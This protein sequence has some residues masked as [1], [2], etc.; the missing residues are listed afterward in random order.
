M[1]EISL[2]VFDGGGGFV[3]RESFVG[4]SS[5]SFDEKKED[6]DHD[7]DVAD[8]RSDGGDEGSDDLLQSQISPEEI[9]AMRRLSLKST[10][11]ATAQGTDSLAAAAHGRDD[12]DTGEHKS[13]SAA[14]GKLA[15]ALD[16][17]MVSKEDE[18]SEADEGEITSPAAAS[19][20]KTSG[21]GNE[22]TRSGGGEG[23]GGGGGGGNG[24]G[25]GRNGNG[26]G[27]GTG[28]GSE[29]K[30]KEETDEMIDPEHDPDSDPERYTT[31]NLRV[32]HRLNRTGFEEHKEF[33]ARLGSVVAG[34]YQLTEFLGSA[35]FSQAVQALDLQTGM[36]VCMK[37]IKNNKDFFDQSLDEVK[38]LKLVNQRDPADAKGL[39]RLYDYFYHREHLFIVTEL[40]R[41]NLYEF[42]KF[43]LESGDEP[44]FTLD[45]LRSIAR[46]V[47]TS[48]AFLHSL[49]LI[50][51]D[52]K[53]EN[54]LIKSYSRCEVKVIDLGS[55]CFVTDH[56]SSYVQSRSYRAPEVIIGARYSTKVDVWSL[57]C[58]LAELHT[59][60]VLFQNDSLASLLARCVGILGPFDP[61]LLARGRYSTRF[62]TRSG[63]V[64]ERDKDTG[65]M[66]VL[67]PKKT[68]LAARLGFDPAAVAAAGTW[69]GRGRK[70][71]GGLGGGG[72]G[73]G[74]GGAGF[75][76]LLL[77]MLQPNPDS[78]PTASE[79][80]SHPWLSTGDPRMGADEE[81][82]E[83]VAGGG[84]GGGI[85]GASYEQTGRDGG[86]GAAPAAAVGARWGMD[87]YEHTRNRVFSVFFLCL[88]C[89]T[90]GATASSLCATTGRNRRVHFVQ[91]S[92]QACESTERQESV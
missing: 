57:G 37:I 83:G 60:E 29:K 82:D 8:G 73:G 40:L 3:V 72:R 22:K 50:H 45:S 30:E 14:A 58:I 15:S 11:A 69:A 70:K 24:D 90:L 34:R 53:P 79:A 86:G 6:D 27:N 35:A 18:D 21:G 74:R 7:M 55:S 65:A 5:A 17:L 85:D 77:W 84:G 4:E 36:M 42:Q 38:L 19:Q 33:P 2:A 16:R 9:E 87:L 91:F 10:T 62:F 26:A 64:Y 66:L 68:T 92:S 23:G 13:A 76:D 39:L 44:Y 43:N 46:Q 51:C 41:A 63:L 12:D 32:V 52:L 48:L 28:N 88:F 47:L 89:L 56:L 81:E 49:D 75:V 54:I 31:F 61:D 80:L 67:Q 59:G 1:D 20:G 78:R 25:Y 71:G